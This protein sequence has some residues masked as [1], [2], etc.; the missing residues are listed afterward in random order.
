LDGTLTKS[1][2]GPNAILAV[3]MAAARGAAAAQKLPLSKYLETIPTVRSANLL[4]VPMMT[5]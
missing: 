2:L 4:P 1:R 3:S 5:S